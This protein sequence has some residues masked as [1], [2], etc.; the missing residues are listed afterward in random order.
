MKKI[1]FYLKISTLILVGV[2]SPL[3]IFSQ[4]VLNIRRPIESFNQISASSS[5]N[6]YIQ[7]GEKEDL[8]VETRE[9][10]QKFVKTEVRGNLL[11]IYTENFPKNWNWREENN[12]YIKVFVTVRDLQKIEASGASDIFF[13]NQLITKSFEL[14]LHGS[15]DAKINLKCY[16]F[17]CDIHGSSDAVLNGEVEEMD[18]KIHGSSDLK[19]YNL[20]VRHCRIQISGSGD[21]FISVNGELD[22][23]V[24]GSGDLNYQGN[25]NIRKMQVSGS[26]DVRRKN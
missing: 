22:A 18:A 6:V 23:T 2:L 14:H 16:N 9:D 15:S 3:A 1:N 7:Q 21:A 25:P 10:L 17:V 13:D 8:R 5:V 4:N 11:A 19:A 20:Q 26:G 12:I 24:S